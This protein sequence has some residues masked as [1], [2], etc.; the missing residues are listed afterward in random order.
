M[1]LEIVFLWKMP[2][3]PKRKG[4]WE[5]RKMYEKWCLGRL[6]QVCSF[7]CL[8][9]KRDVWQYIPQLASWEKEGIAQ[10]G[11]V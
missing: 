10:E 2:E 5:E 11:F 7:C 9:T 8:E 4:G 1:V 6:C 3:N